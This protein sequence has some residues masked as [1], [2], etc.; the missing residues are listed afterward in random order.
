MKDIEER[1]EKINKMLAFIEENLDKISNNNISD[2]E[3][4]EVLKIINEK[5]DNFCKYNI[6]SINKNE[7]IEVINEDDNSK[8]IEETDS[9]KQKEQ[10]V[11]D[12]QQALNECPKDDKKEKE[13][14]DKIEEERKHEENVFVKIWNAIKHPFIRMKEK[15]EYKNGMKELSEIRFFEDGDSRSYSSHLYDKKE[16][17]K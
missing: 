5:L 9:N 13:M 7:K 2:E 12:Y 10:L 8:K 1:N 11:E 4:E 15:R 14:L 6:S 16:D 3:T 17:K